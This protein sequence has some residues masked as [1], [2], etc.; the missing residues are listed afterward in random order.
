MVQNKHRPII[1]IL[2]SLSLSLSDG[3]VK[4]DIGHHSD[5]F[6]FLSFLLHGFHFFVVLIMGS[7]DFLCSRICLSLSLRLDDLEQIQE[8][9]WWWFREN[10]ARSRPLSRSRSRPLSR[11]RSRPLSRPKWSSISDWPLSFLH[12]FSFFLFIFCFWIVGLIMIWLWWGYGLW[13]YWLWLVVVMDCG[14]GGGGAELWVLIVVVVEWVATLRRFQFFFFPFWSWILF[15]FGLLVIWKMRGIFGLDSE[16]LICFGCVTEN[17]EL[18]LQ[19][20]C[21]CVREEKIQC[22]YFWSMLCLIF[23]KM[24]FF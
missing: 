16:D 2:L 8:E 4:E 12:G 13:G 9:G 11:S 18:Y 21:S 15:D 10:G 24:V 20:L 3:G 5:G 1:S 17:F 6:H 19:M 23:N 7:S 14:R 22:L